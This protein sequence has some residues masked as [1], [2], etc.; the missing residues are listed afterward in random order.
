MFYNG[1]EIPS[2]Y[3]SDTDMMA[4]LPG[5]VP[6]EH[7]ISV[8]NGPADGD[9]EYPTCEEP[10]TYEHELLIEDLAAGLCGF[11]KFEGNAH[12]LSGKANDGDVNGATLTLNRDNFEA[13][14][15]R[16][17]DGDYISVSPCTAGEG[18]TVA[19]WVYY[20]DADLPGYTACKG[21]ELTHECQASAN[22]TMNEI[23]RAHV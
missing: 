13:Q 11:Y 17:T 5:S 21:Y 7:A 4:V 12:D 6:A 23:G 8:S 15:Y 18:F 1:T 3:V 9:M 20:A 19:A 2:V 22:A 14:A 10:V 16:F